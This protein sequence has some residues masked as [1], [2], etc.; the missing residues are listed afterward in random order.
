MIYKNVSY[1]RNPYVSIV[2]AYALYRERWRKNI[3]SAI[4]KLDKIDSG[5]NSEVPIERSIL[6]YANTIFNAKTICG[7]HETVLQQLILWLEPMYLYMMIIYTLDY[8][9]KLVSCGGKSRLCQRI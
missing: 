5:F 8:Y 2:L 4:K 3:I 6:F 1:R 7:G 9:R